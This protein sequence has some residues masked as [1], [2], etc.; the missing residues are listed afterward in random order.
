MW[1]GACLNRQTNINSKN[2]GRRSF[3]MKPKHQY[4]L[5]KWGECVY[6]AESWNEKRLLCE[7]IFSV[8][9]RWNLILKMVEREVFLMKPKQ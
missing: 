5:S 8:T 3:P 6:G 1:I 7:P 9:E 4:Y 2:G